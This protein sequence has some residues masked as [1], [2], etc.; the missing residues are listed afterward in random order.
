M[1]EIRDNELVSFL[2]WVLPKMGYRWAGFKKVRG[3]VKK[4]ISRRIDELKL[5]D[6]TAYKSYLKTHEEEWQRLDGFCWITISR[7]YRDRATWDGLRKKVLPRCARRA[8]E[9]GRE[10][11]YAWSIGCASGEEPYTLRLCWELDEMGPCRDLD[12]A[13]DAIDAAPHMIERA[14]RGVYPPGNLKELPSDWRRRAFEKTQQGCRLRPEFRRGVRFSVA[15]FRDAKPGRVYDLVFCRNLAFMYFDRPGRRRA[16]AKIADVMTDGGAL[17][18]GS[19]DRIPEPSAPYM[20]WS[21]VDNTW[22]KRART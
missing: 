4:R 7:F 14:Q 13:V 2:Q 12:L 17:V 15:D 8:R 10:R 3:Q 6:L 9:A 16:L 1:V 19:H 11:L 18:V 21:G 5:D 20:P 22:R